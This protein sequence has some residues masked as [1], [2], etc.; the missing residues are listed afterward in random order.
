MF[1]IKDHFFRW[2]FPEASPFHV[3]KTIESGNVQENNPDVEGE[4]ILTSKVKTPIPEL[5]VSRRIAELEADGTSDKRKRV[6]FGQCISPE[7]FDKDTPVR[8]GA[9][10]PSELKGE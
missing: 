3:K 4:K 1:T 10:P 7:L 2:E 9:V 8:K 6:S 5:P